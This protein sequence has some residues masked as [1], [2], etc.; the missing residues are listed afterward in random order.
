LKPLRVEQCDVARGVAGGGDHIERADPIA[1][2]HAS[3]GLGLGAWVASAELVLRLVRIEAHVFGQQPRVACRDDHLRLGKPLLQR[4]ERADVVC[5]CVREEDADD[6]RAACLGAG[7][8]L[9]RGA[10][11][12][13]V[14]QGQ[15][16]VLAHQVGV[17]HPQPGDPIHIS[18]RLARLPM[19]GR[20]GRGRSKTPSRVS[21][22]STRCPVQR[23]AASAVALVRARK[24]RRGL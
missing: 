20:T 24:G 19:G 15:P 17:H 2:L 4:V 21:Y 23:V 16:V 1:G 3:V 6:R 22:R 14:D 13:R 11:E 18:H 9:A 12:H 7:D 8:D 10:P 5:V